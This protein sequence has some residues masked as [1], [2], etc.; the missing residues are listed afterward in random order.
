VIPIAD[1]AHVWRGAAAKALAADGRL[2][3][4]ERLA[5][6]AV[7]IAGRTDVLAMRGDALL[8]L[9]EVAPAAGRRGDAAAA[10]QAALEP[11]RAKGSLPGAARARAAAAAAQL[12]TPSRAAGDA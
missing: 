6:E 7:T 5:G 10:A 2:E 1:L 4:A 9:A 3:E 8:D 12:T 11:Y